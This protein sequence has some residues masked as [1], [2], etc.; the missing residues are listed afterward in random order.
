[1]RAKRFTNDLQGETRP[2]RTS[3]AK[4]E[5]MGRDWGRQHGA[6]ALPYGNLIH[7]AACA[8]AVLEMTGKLPDWGAERLKEL[9]L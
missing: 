2:R 8:R 1:M 7:D 9:G 5:A 6:K 4:L 3:R